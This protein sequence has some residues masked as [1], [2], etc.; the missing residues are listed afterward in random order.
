MGGRLAARV[1]DKIAAGTA[2]GIKQD[3][4]QAS[5]APKLTKENGVIDWSRSAREVCNQIR[6]MQPWPTAYTYW[7]RQGQPPLRLILHKAAWREAPPGDAIPPGQIIVQSKEAFRLI[8]AAGSG[9]QVEILE[10]QP[11]GKRRMA[12]AEFLRG[13]RL[14]PGDHLG[15]ERA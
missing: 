7:H 1:V 2:Q 13:H 6:A 11:A 14:E 10:L 15:P 5:R 4:S 3:K 9:S 8:V 12:A